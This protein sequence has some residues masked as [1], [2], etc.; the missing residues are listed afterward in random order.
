[1]KR[2]LLQS[3]PLVL[4]VAA[5][6]LLPSAP[7]GAAEDDE[8]TMRDLVR[9]Y[10]KDKDPAELK[11]ATGLDVHHV[12]ALEHTI[13]L[14]KDGKAEPL[15]EPEK[16]RFKIGE[17][18]RIRI[19]PVTDAYLY[20]FNEGASGER[21]C[22]MPDKD[23]KAPL[24]KAGESVDLPL[25]GSSFEFIA[26][27]G[28]ELVRVV[29]TDKPTEDLAGLLNAVFKKDNLTPKEE[30]LKKSIRAK[31]EARLQSI[32]KQQEQAMTYRGLLSKEAMKDVR[33]KIEQA[34]SDE[35]V[36]RELP[37]AKHTST[38]TMIV[39]AKS[40]ARPLM[41]SIPLESILEK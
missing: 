23:E 25:D 11:A 16:H 30:D 21:V 7:A 40:D 32:G 3:F 18:I 36:L 28:K 9:R 6:F 17:Q 38:F 19:R 4:L 41:L 10:A 39:Q 22:L 15:L 1:M 26:P 14:V 37:S 24:V 13:L 5:P 31:I 34:G 29:A 12:L 35:V 2:S 33:A 8:M 27:P 20:I